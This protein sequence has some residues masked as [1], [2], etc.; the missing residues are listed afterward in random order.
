MGESE[1][2]LKLPP[3]ADESLLVARYTA[4]IAYE[5]LDVVNRSRFR[6]SKIF[7]N[8]TWNGL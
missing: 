1:L 6:N 4:L 2:I 5:K 7:Q 3:S 8:L